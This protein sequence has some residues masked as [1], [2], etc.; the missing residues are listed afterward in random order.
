MFLSS[1]E[2]RGSRS[3]RHSG[4]SD[5]A[6]PK[7]SRRRARRVPVSFSLLHLVEIGAIAF[8]LHIVA[9]DEPQRGG[10][11]AVTQAAAIPRAV[12]D[13]V[14]EMAVAV[15]RTYL[16]ADHAVRAVS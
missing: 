14:A 4:G 16:R 15:G 10:I 7:S 5:P 8:G 11:D 1:I 9:V 3:P 13:D 2:L 6:F 12:G